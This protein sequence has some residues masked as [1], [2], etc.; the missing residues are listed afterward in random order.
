MSYS[1]K[2]CTVQTYAEELDTCK[3]LN[4]DLIWYLSSQTFILLARSLPIGTVVLG[5]TCDSAER[6]LQ[7]AIDT[8]YDLGVDASGLRQRE[9]LAFAAVNVGGYAKK[10][11]VW[12]K[13]TSDI[14]VVK[15]SVQVKSK[16]SYLLRC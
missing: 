2:I 12:A 9:A 11:A 15:I 4:K 3:R 1:A 8:L 13:V 16:E 10:N 7:P 6:K 5:Y 14:G